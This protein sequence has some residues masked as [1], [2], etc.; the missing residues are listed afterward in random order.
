MNLPANRKNKFNNFLKFLEE[1]P[2][3]IAKNEQNEMVVEGKTLEGSNTDDLIRNIY[4]HNSNYNLTGIHDFSQ[5]LSKPNLSNSAISNSKFKQF[6]SPQKQTQFPTPVISAQRSPAQQ[7]LQKGRNVFDIS[8]HKRCYQG[9]DFAPNHESWL[10]P[11]KD[12]P[13]FYLL[14]LL[15]SYS[16]GSTTEQGAKGKRAPPG[17]RPRMLKLYR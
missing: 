4:V 8:A 13:G 5:A 6:M 3:I 7:T 17:K 9:K 12:V 15:K 14:N 16:K 10:P 2:D 11:Q 1:N